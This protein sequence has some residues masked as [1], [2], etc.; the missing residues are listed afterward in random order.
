MTSQFGKTYLALL[1][2][3]KI[4]SLVVDRVIQDLWKGGGEVAGLLNNTENPWKLDIILMILE[5]DDEWWKQDIC[6]TIQNNKITSV[7][8]FDVFY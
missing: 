7:W 1:I 3:I 2:R 6:T 8:N 4:T 5:K